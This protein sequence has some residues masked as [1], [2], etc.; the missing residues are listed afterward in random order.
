MRPKI[1]TIDILFENIPK[2]RTDS[3]FHRDSFA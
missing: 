3:E 1:V 2:A